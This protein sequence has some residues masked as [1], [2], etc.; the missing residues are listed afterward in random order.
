MIVARA[1]VVGEDPGLLAPLS[2]T[3][4]LLLSLGWVLVVV[5]WTVWRVWTHQ[6]VWRGSGVEVALLALVVMQFASGALAAAY[7]RPAW[8]IG[9]EW[10][11]LLLAVLHVRQ[12]ATEPGDNRGLLA[13]VLATGISLSAYAI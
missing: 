1:Q 6:T 2:G 4:S 11:I 13:A 10:G 5:G 9:W 3:A 12:L 7:K 8:L